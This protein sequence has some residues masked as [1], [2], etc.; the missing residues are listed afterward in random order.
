[1]TIKNRAPIEYVLFDWDG[2]L[3]NSFEADSN[4]YM[5]MF[6]ALGMSWSVMPVDHGFMM[7]GF[8]PLTAS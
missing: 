7:T 3:L 6:D 2:T 5:N 1:M 8:L 4:A